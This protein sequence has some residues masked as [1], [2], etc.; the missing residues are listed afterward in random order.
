MVK[1][2]GGEG[3]E[4]G[5]GGGGGERNKMGWRMVGEEWGG[6]GEVG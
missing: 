3:G 4:K 5:K 1:I 2:K 6:G